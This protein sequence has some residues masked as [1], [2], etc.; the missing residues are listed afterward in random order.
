MGGSGAGGY[1]GGTRLGGGFA[2]GRSPGAAAAAAADARASASASAPG[3]SSERRRRDEL[4]GRLQE[5]YRRKGSQPPMGLPTM[6]LKRL[7][8]IF[9]K[10]NTFS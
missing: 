3:V 8:E 7:E 6:P 2:D 1:G 9:A 4:I 5:L 10:M